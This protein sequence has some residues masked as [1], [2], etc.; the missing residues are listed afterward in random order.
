MEVLREY[1]IRETR[2]GDDRVHLELEGEGDVVHL[3]VS[4]GQSAAAPRNGAAR[5]QVDKDRLPNVIEHI[6]HKLHLRQVLLIP[7]ARWRA[8]FD[9]VAFSMASNE[10]WQ[11]ID[12]TATVEQNTR[13]PILCEPGDFQTLKAL[14]TAL[15]ADGETADQGLMVTTTGA[16]LMVELVPDGAL[17]ISIGSR[18]MADELAEVFAASSS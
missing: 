12:A 3:H 17:R 14:I 9:A 7:V 5:L 15:L 11:E 18:V 10:D 6:M 4:C 16:P 1:G 13:D 2:H 8:V